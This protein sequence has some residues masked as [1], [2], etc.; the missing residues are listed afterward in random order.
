M[1]TSQVSYSV[2]PIIKAS[3]PAPASSMEEARAY[4]RTSPVTCTSL[5]RLRRRPFIHEMERCL[6]EMGVNLVY[7]ESVKVKDRDHWDLLMSLNG[8]L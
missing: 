2:P 1:E 3:T 6:V 5:Q 8:G 7:K 4:R